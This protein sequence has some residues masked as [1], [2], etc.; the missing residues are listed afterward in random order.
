MYFD[1]K[2][3]LNNKIF[4]MEV[5]R[6]YVPDDAENIKEA[7]LEDDFGKIQIDAGGLFVGYAEKTADKYTASLTE[8]EGAVKI[9]FSLPKNIVTLEKDTS[10]AMSCDGSKEAALKE[11]SALKVA[12]LKCDVFAL[13]IEKRI[14]AAVEEW[15][16]EITDF[17]TKDPTGFDVSLS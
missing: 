1:T 2:K 8:S 12:E 7:Q 5:V 11:I 3:D 9:A 13:E 4:K 6:K 17:E 15:K 10:I 16:A 14:N